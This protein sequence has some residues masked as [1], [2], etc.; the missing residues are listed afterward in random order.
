MAK[1]YICHLCGFQPEPPSVV[2]SCPRDGSRLVPFSEHEK[3]PHDPYLG[4]TLGERYALE[5]GRAH[6]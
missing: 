3:S 5:I 2:Q 6:V 4:R 1:S